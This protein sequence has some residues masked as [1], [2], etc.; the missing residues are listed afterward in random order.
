MLI[1][2]QDSD[3]TR[4]S[5]RTKLITARHTWDFRNHQHRELWAAWKPGTMAEARGETEEEAI[6]NLMKKLGMV[7]QVEEKLVLA[8]GPERPNRRKEVDAKFGRGSNA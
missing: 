3:V 1:R 6:G 4:P 7:D 2:D 8:G 5:I